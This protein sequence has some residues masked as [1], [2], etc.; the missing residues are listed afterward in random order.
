MY[1]RD[2]GQARTLEL[3]FRVA[4]LQRLQPNWLRLVRQLATSESS[5]MGRWVPKSDANTKKSFAVPG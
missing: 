1:E 2:R 5:P 4:Y 3:T